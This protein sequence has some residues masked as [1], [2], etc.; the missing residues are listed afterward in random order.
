LDLLYSLVN[1]G[2]IRLLT[3]ELLDYLKVTDADFKPD[4]TAKICQLVQRFAPD[5]KWHLD[6][7]LEVRSPNDNPRT[8]FGGVPV[9]LLL[10]FPGSVDGIWTPSLRSNLRLIALVPLL[11]GCL[12]GYC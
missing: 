9:V 11:V 12:S 1:E 3:K 8:S 7:L 4:L 5:R 10:G 6:S 2:N